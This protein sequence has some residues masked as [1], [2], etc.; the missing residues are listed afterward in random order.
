MSDYRTVISA[1][2]MH[3]R[4]RPHDIPV[5][6]FHHFCILQGGPFVKCHVA[7]CHT[8]LLHYQEILLSLF[9]LPAVLC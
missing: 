6:L 3:V 8:S 4:V 7:W 2:E 5:D 1:E 9:L